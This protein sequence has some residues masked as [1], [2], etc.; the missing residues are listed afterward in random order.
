MRN[1]TPGILKVL[2]FL[3]AGVPSVLAS[4]ADKVRRF[5]ELDSAGREMRVRFI[6]CHGAQSRS[7]DALADSNRANEVLIRDLHYK[8]S[9]GIDVDSA[10][11]AMGT[12]VTHCVFD[13]HKAPE[14]CKEEA[15]VL[16]PLEMCVYDA[17]SSS[18]PVS[19]S[20]E[21]SDRCR[22]SS[23]Q[24]GI[25]PPRNDSGAAQ[26]TLSE[27][28]SFSILEFRTKTLET[29]DVWWRIGWVARLKNQWS[30]AIVVTGRVQFLDKDGFAVDGADLGELSLGAN[31]TESFTGYKLVSSTT[32]PTIVG[33]KYSIHRL[34]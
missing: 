4:Q 32:A 19:A 6:E 30:R 10:R 11:K 31:A 8:N 29:N 20:V 3:M 24:D 15:R 5:V 1:N 25:L 21:Q 13:L 34:Q 14:S 9:A 2:V 18:A 23:G 17:F 27:D 7:C 28:G 16:H 26:P 22:P 12:I 33:W